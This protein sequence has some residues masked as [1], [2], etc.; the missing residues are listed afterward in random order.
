MSTGGSNDGI[1]LRKISSS[2]AQFETNIQRVSGKGISILLTGIVY[3][4]IG[5]TNLFLD[6]R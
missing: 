2:H 1:W 5:T 6:L 4:G 3:G